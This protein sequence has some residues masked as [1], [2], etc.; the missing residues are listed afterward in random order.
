MKVVRGH[1]AAVTW[2]GSIV[3]KWCMHT[4]RHLLRRRPQHVRRRLHVFG[5]VRGF[6][7]ADVNAILLTFG[8]AG[9]VQSAGQRAES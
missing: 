9:R 6:E 2:A 1:A 4:D 7:L 3:E 8:R 5:Q